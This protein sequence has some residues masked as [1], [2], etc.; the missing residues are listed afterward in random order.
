MD[1]KIKG[2]TWTKRSLND[3]E[4][5]TKF[6]IKLYG[7]DKALEISTSLRK[8][9]EILESSEVD[10]TEYGSIDESFKHLKSEYRKLI[11]NYCKI[12]YRVGKTKIYI[13]RVF[14]TRQHPKK[15]K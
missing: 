8:S 11:N 1:R 4:K 12:T 2:I 14:D 3:L 7:P 6:N 15:N 10:V 5:V 9:T 13:I